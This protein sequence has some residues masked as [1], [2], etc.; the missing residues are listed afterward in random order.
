LDKLHQTRRAARIEKARASTL[1]T[2]AGLRPGTNFMEKYDLDDDGRLDAHEW[3]VCRR[4]QLKLQ[5]AM[6]AA[7]STSSPAKP[8]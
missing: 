4:D 5:A 8:P 2:L 6:K 1:S 7:T 3:M